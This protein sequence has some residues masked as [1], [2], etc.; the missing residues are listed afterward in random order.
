MFM[1]AN[2]LEDDTG[3]MPLWLCHE[4]AVLLRWMGKPV[5]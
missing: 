1:D 4:V 2:T 5:V 3:D